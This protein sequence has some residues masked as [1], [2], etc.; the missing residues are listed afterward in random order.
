MKVLIAC[1]ESQRVCIEFR[2]RG[3]EAYSADIQEPS[4]GHPEWHILGD[5]LRILDGGRFATMDGIVHEV[6]RWDLL[7]A[8]PPCTFL[9]VAGAANIPKH[10]D[11]VEKGFTAKAFFM[12]FIN[13]DCNRI[14]V[15]NPAPMKRFEL[16]KYTQIC[17]PYW[18]GENNNKPICLWLK[19]L[20][21]LVPTNKIKYNPDNIYW[22]HKRTGKKKSSSKWYNQN[23]KN[24][25]LHRSKTFQGFA[26]AMAEQW[27]CMPEYEVQL[28]LF[29]MKEE[30]HDTI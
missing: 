24:H 8:H 29:D 30:K 27:G 20:P 14:C 19:N 22:I 2:K 10:P 25:S 18:F 28:S 3:H 1:E 9:T 11:R 6:D 26:A 15:E 4:G 5:V 16:P 17:R 21:P 12:K 13:A 23:T 7:I